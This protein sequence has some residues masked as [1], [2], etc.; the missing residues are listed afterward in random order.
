MKEFSDIIIHPEQSMFSAIEKIT[1]NRLQFVLVV[2][3][4]MQLLGIVTDGD[5]R[6][7]ILKGLGTD[8]KVTELMNPNPISVKKDQPSENIIQLMKEKKIRHCPVVDSKNRLVGI[9]YIDDFLGINKYDNWV[10]I[11]AGG[12]GKRLQPL[13]NKIPKPM[14]EV[15]GKPMLENIIN[16]LCEQG[17]QNIFLSVNYLA[18]MIQEYFKNG[19]E[20]GVNIQY[21]KESKRMGTAGS[22]SLLNKPPQKPVLVMNCDLATNINY[23]SLLD[24]HKVHDCFATMCVKEYDLAVPY[25]VV[26]TKGTQ[27]IRLDE[28][29][30]E[31]IF[32]NAGIYVLQPEAIKMIKRDTFYDMP[33][34]FKQIIKISANAQVFPIL[35]KWTDIGSTDDL[36]QVNNNISD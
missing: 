21:I 26:K 24:F 15:N 36:E 33:E 20:F 31:K 3:E 19:S 8:R 22:L 17:F 9:H 32:V 13:T 34:L 11:M 14:L 5:I 6:R 4:E 12:L 25:G 35:E 16:N 30:V 23:R 18:D 28:K 1:E 2:N 27:I 29:P 7:S 10:I